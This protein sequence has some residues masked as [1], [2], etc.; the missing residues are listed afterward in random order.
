[1]RRDKTLGLF[2]LRSGGF[3]ISVAFSVLVGEASE[4]AKVSIN[5]KDI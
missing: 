2:P 5:T 3:A 4:V 1:M